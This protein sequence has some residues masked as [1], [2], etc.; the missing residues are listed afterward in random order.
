MTPRAHAPSP[1]QA[2]ATT[3]CWQTG[4]GAHVSRNRPPRGGQRAT[5]TMTVGD[6]APTARLV[7]LLASPLPRTAPRRANRP[8]P[9]RPLPSPQKQ[10]PRAGASERVS[11]GHARPAALAPH[12]GLRPPTVPFTSAPAAD[13]PPH[14]R[15]SVG[16]PASRGRRRAQKLRP[17]SRAPS[18][19]AATRP[20]YG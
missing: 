17:P 6:G 8:S 20:W 5:D 18:A 3:D 11:T 14:D 10:G 9:T 7:T 15:S 1:P 2:R 16:S 12:S 4:R 19:S 13:C